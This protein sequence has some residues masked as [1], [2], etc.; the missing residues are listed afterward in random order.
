MNFH[1]MIFLLSL[2]SLLDIEGSKVIDSLDSVDGIPKD[3]QLE[4]WSA[5]SGYDTVLIRLL[6]S[7][8]SCT[9]KQSC[10]AKHHFSRENCTV[11]PHQGTSGHTAGI[12]RDKSQLPEGLEPSPPRSFCSPNHC[13]TAPLP[14]HLKIFSP[15]QISASLES[16]DGVVL[17]FC[18][19]DA[20][21]WFRSQTLRRRL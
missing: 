13:A 15:I 21:S 10:I 5:C 11:A 19:R 2:Q 16:V 20:Q 3:C 12:A 14:K 9:S 7:A 1:L 18:R 4:V 8:I 17:N 6:V